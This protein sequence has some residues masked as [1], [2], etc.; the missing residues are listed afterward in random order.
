M[1]VE[2]EEISGALRE[3]AEAFAEFK[4]GNKRDLADLER[5]FEAKANRERLGLGGGSERAVERTQSAT[6]TREQ[7]AQFER[8]ARTGEVER[9][10]SMMTINDNASGGY[11]AP[12]EFAREVESIGAEEGAIRKLARGFDTRTGDF[13]IPILTSLAA[14]SWVGETGTRSSTATPDVG[15]IHPMHGSI[16]AVAPVSNYLLNDAGY[17]VASLITESIGQQFGVSEA[18]SFIS[19][20][21]VNKPSGFLMNAQTEQADA[22]RAFGTVQKVKSGSTTVIS[23]DAL[24]S[25]R[26]ALAPRYRAK[27][28]WVMHPSTED[29]LRKLRVSV[30]GPLAWT[31]SLAEASPS[32]LLGNPVLL[33]TAMPEIGANALP[34][35]IA[36][37]TKF[38]ATVSI[39]DLTLIRDAVTSKG[40]TLFYAEKRVGGAVLD[41]NAA[42][43]MIMA[44]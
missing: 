20:N 6:M 37:W 15:K 31:P 41:S 34:I 35:A 2:N 33:D 11:L 25:L 23:I 10:A 17:D 3:L 4:A 13:H 21:G 40:N 12:P 42:K 32:T 29:Y 43:L 38:Y 14:A 22:A 16:Y 9:K 18:A 19:G 28:A 24:L 44:S 27:A 30:D 5:K 36:D 26:G 1:A 7:K 39:G 8:F